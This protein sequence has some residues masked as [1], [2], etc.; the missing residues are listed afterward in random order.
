MAKSWKATERRM[1]GIGMKKVHYCEIPGFSGYEAGT[2]GSIWSFWVVGCK[3]RI[4]RR[5][6]K[7]MRFCNDTNGYPMVTL[8]KDRGKP[9]R[10]RVHSIIL[11]TFI[12]PRPLGLEACHRNGD[13]E[14]NRLGNLRWGTHQSNNMDKRRHGTAP[15]GEKN[16]TAKLTDNTVIALR[17]VREEEKISFRELG[18]RFNV[19]AD[20]AHRACTKRTWGHLD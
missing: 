15:V 13:R 2:D 18:K 3:A 11:T 4:D 8:Y 7:K 20:T 14:D 9:K 17:R 5:R 19:C 6:R 10:V 12:C 1:V 16:P